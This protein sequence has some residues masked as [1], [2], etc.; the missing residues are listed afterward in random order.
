M[1]RPP[2]LHTW[3]L[4]NNETG[5]RSQRARQQVLVAYERR[6][7]VAADRI[8]VQAGSLRQLGLTPKADMVSA[9]VPNWNR[10]SRNASRE[11]YKKAAVRHVN[12]N[13][14]PLIR[15]RL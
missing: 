5:D 9:I 7:T 15:A 10:A 13:G 12:G 6:P 3:V 14:L 4:Q 2:G 1:A 11:L 8:V